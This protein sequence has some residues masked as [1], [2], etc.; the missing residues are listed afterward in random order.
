VFGTSLQLAWHPSFS[1]YI[2]HQSPERFTA[3]NPFPSYVLFIILPLNSLNIHQE[4][5]LPLPSSQYH[6]TYHFFISSSVFA[7]PLFSVRPSVDLRNWFA[8]LFLEVRL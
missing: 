3:V 7:A 1:N 4:E 8:K 2:W 5:T 6:Y